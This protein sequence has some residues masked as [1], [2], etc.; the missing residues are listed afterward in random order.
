MDLEGRKDQAVD[1]RNPPP[2]QTLRGVEQASQR[3]GLEGSLRFS[4]ENIK[5]RMTSVCGEVISAT[6]LVL[7]PFSFGQC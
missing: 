4:A 1:W 6:C 3:S 2:F 7:T 5:E